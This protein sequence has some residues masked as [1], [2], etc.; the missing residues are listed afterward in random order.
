MNA[1]MLFIV[2]FSASLAA[3]GIVLTFVGVMLMV[4][5]ARKAER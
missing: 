4:L 5:S 2:C 3:F 1:Q